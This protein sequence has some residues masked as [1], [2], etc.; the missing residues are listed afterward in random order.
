MY[1]VVTRDKKWYASRKNGMARYGS[2][3]API[4]FPTLAAA[5]QFANGFKWDNMYPLQKEYYK[6][7]CKGGDESELFREAFQWTPPMVQQSLPFIPFTPQPT[8]ACYLTDDSKGLIMYQN[9]K[10]DLPRFNSTQYK[11]VG[12]SEGYGGM[13]NQ[14]P[15]RYY[16]HLISPEPETSP[17]VDITVEHQLA[18]NVNFCRAWINKGLDLSEGFGIWRA[19]VNNRELLY[20]YQKRLTSILEESK[21]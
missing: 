21:S 16:D 4:I 19:F 13:F 12:Y 20:R 1:I 6:W 2:V 18:F 15:K 3:S 17:E 7:L 5:I 9:G 14:M 10:V 11:V 8:E